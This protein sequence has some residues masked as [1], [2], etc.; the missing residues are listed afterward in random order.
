MPANAAPPARLLAAA[1]AFHAAPSPARPQPRPLDP[2]RGAGRPLCA[3]AYLTW[4]RFYA[5]I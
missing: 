5:I 1:S 2:Q 3:G 4:K